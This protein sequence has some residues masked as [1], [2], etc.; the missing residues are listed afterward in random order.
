ML[1]VPADVSGDIFYNIVLLGFGHREGYIVRLR[2]LSWPFPLS[3]I[4]HHRTLQFV[5]DALRKQA[6]PDL[7][8]GIPPNSWTI[9]DSRFLLWCVLAH[10]SVW[11]IHKFDDRVVFCTLLCIGRCHCVRFLLLQA[12]QFLSR[13]DPSKFDRRRGFS[14]RA[15]AA[16]FIGTIINFL[17][18]SLNTGNQVAVV[19]VFIRKGLMII[20]DSD[21]PLLEKPELV[22]NALRNEVMVGFW[23]ETFPVGTKLL[24]PDHLQYLFIL[25]GAISQWSHCRLE[26]MGPLPRSTVGRP[27]PIYSVDWRR[28]W[29]YIVRLP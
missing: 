27:H 9:V 16:M 10:A 7:W 6:S 24:I 26:G 4:L 8:F 3:L 18:A 2:L 20:L 12:T 15:I 17:L 25:G 21:Y 19:I 11:L 1:R 23:A 28:G 29:I 14:N 13:P 5:H 22:T